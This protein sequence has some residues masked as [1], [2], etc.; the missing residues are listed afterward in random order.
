[1]RQKDSERG[2]LL[3]LAVGDAMGYVV[4]RKGY[5][6]IIHDYGPNGLMGYDLVNG[7]ADVSSYTQ[8]AAYAGNGLLLGAT[9]GRMRGVM[10]PYVKYIE[11]A[12]K[13]WASTQRFGTP[14]G[15]P[16]YCWVSGVQELK[17]R[18]CMDSL[19]ADNLNSGRVGSLEEPSNRFQN[20]GSITA[21]VP[22]GLFLNPKTTSRQEILRLGAEAVALT[23]GNPLAFLGGALI[24]HI[25][26]R[27]VWDGADD[28]YAL[29]DEAAEL[30][31]AQFGSQYPQTVETVRL[32]QMAQGL[33]RA[34]NLP[35]AQAMEQLDCTN[36]VRVVAGAIFCVLTYPDDLDG[37]VIAAVN[38]SGRSAACGAIAGAISGA[39]LGEARLPSFYLDCLQPGD[40]LRELADDLYQG[41][42]MGADSRLFDAEWA[43][44]Y[45]HG[46][47]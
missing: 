14:T 6:D 19:M 41:C 7:Y 4:D 40:A 38:H 32:L 37:A 43:G 5:D 1:M 45:L 22:A 21:A 11:L 3:G 30:L 18:R 10:A 36:G 34:G 15:Q 20:P 46:G 17:F 33:A 42:P 29:T 23:H 39:L 31:Q 47:N 28:L 27:I 35:V 2:C 13:E 24:A 12:E 9:R 26:S 25:L 44:K 8:I 16:P